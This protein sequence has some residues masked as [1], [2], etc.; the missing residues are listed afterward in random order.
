MHAPV[1][2]ST[3]TAVPHPGISFREFVALIASLMA[4]NS[5]AIDIMLPALPDIGAAMMVLNEN[6]SQKVL[7]AYLI[8]FG[9]AQL[10]YGPVSDR[11]G[12]RPVL[13]GGLALYA[14]AGVF[15]IFAN[16][17]SHLLAAR[18]VQ[19]IGCA[20][21]RVVAVSIVRDSYSGRQMGRV[22]SLVMMVFMV[23]PIFAPS[24]GQI[25]LFVG[26]WRAIFLFLTLGGVVM[27]VWC[28]RRLPET[29][30]AAR[31]QPVSARSI[32]AAY[33]TTLTTRV[34]FGYM[35]ASGLIF[36]A[37]FGFIAS[38]QQ[39]F[40]ETFGIGAAFPVVFALIGLCMAAA[41][42]VNASLVERIGLRPLSH[43]ALVA[44]VAISLLQ[45]A[46]ALWVAENLY[47]FT[48][49]LAITLFIFGFIGPSFNAIAMEPLGEIAGTGSSVLGFVTTLAGAFCGFIVGQHYDGTVVP[50][51]L[52]FA[53]FGAIALG[54]IFVTEK[55]RLFRTTQPPR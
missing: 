8:G 54:I 23:V 2:G 52:G 25:I 26:P 41:S 15:S 43:G 5:L 20:A 24:L 49:M 13:L 7:I 40:V 53:T 3:A 44:F 37:L 33:V 35:C 22:M 1:T 12:R 27:L 36:G 21:P 39:I 9:G 4:L 47:V 38:A 19:G 14:A 30:P 50:L 28:A 16:D 10:F 31:R 32:V 48:A 46:T 42:F 29:L 11:Y 51:S 6:D 17:M 34:T 45:A 55:G 18:L